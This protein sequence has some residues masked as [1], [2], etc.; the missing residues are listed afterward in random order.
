MFFLSKIVDKKP[1]PTSL[2][3]LPVVLLKARKT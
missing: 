3:I 2:E 1:K